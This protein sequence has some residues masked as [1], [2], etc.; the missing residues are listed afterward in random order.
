MQSDS[1]SVLC[2]EY[3]TNETLCY[4]INAICEVSSGCYKITPSA[5][6]SFF[7]RDYYLSTVKIE[8]IYCGKIFNNIEFN[9]I[10]NAGL[11]Y[12]VE[13]KALDYLNRCEQCKSSLTLKLQKKGFDVLSI[14]K[15]IDYLVKK[16]YLSDYRFAVSWLRNRRITNSEGKTKLYMMLLSKGISSNIAK[17]ALK[18]FFSEFNEEDMLK[19]AYAKCL[20]KNIP[21][22]KIREKLFYYGFSNEMI[23]NYL[24]NR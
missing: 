1:N 15:A 2:E 23:K 11:A 16:N 9:E 3:S 10:I 24:I 18:E 19:K 6:P 21:E 13:R 4:S 14:N 22:E 20:R 8:D 12:T 17:E 5:G 7:F